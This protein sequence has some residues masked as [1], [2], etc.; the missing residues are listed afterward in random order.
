MGA[1]R[2]QSV[3]GARAAYGLLAP[4][5]GAWALGGLAAEKPAGAGTQGLSPLGGAVPGALPGAAA[6][7]G[8]FSTRAAFGRP[9][10]E[11]RQL[12]G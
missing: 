2:V 7:C 4:R 9:C 5:R 12:S 11:Q 3:R 8:R 6:D 1:E 10:S